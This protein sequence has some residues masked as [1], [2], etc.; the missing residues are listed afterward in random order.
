MSLKPWETAPDRY[1]ALL[2][3]KCSQA[4]PFFQAIGAPEPEIVRSPAQSYRVRAEFRI[5]HDGDEL[6]Y[7][8]FDR[9]APRVPVP[10]RDFA[11][12]IAPIRQLMPRLRAYL[13]DDA[14]LR[15]KLFQVE[16]LAARS[17]EVLVT[18]IYHRALDAAWEAAARALGATLGI[19]VIGRSRKQ[20][21][22]LETDFVTETFPVGDRAYRYR[23]YEQSFVQPNA[24]VNERMLDWACRQAIDSAGDLLELYCGNGNFTLPL[25]R[26][27]DAVLATELS[28]IGTR[29]AQENLA[30]NG[31]DNVSVVR[32][33]AEEVSE[34]FAGARSFRRLAALP[35]PLADY[36]LGT[37]FVDPPR[38]GLDAATLA[39]VRGFDT[40]LYISCNPTTLLANLEQLAQSHR[41]DALAFFDQFPYTDHLECGVR[42][43]RR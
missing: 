16:F 43:R 29:A 30:A 12:A 22:T 40:I 20:K 4:W 18:L 38:A 6:D 19:A 24:P 23:Q 33:S 28:K 13:R 17:G 27:F 15:R 14:A 32:L 8:M 5:W 3:Q 2:D 41:I 36:R 11:P 21:I 26:H 42:L 10:V 39:C 1:G 25:A 35:R 34:A 31:I 7:V 9:D 37:V